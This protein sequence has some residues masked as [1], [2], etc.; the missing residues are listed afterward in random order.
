MLASL[1]AGLC[2]RAS[3]GAAG[4]GWL[5]TVQALGALAAAAGR[6]HVCFEARLGGGGPPLRACIELICL[7]ACMAGGGG[8]ALRDDADGATSCTVGQSP[9]ARYAV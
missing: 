7:H 1:H 6:R 2:V 3:R 5:R 8:H 4:G 9:L